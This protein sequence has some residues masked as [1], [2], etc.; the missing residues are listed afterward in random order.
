MERALEPHLSSIVHH[1]SDAFSSPILQIGGANIAGADRAWQPPTSSSLGTKSVSPHS[2]SAR[3]RA[4]R[5]QQS[6]KMH[7]QAV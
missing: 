6:A 1:C 3:R 7:G 4:I 5:S 2:S